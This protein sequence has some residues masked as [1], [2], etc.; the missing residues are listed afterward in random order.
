[1]AGFEVRRLVPAD[2]SEVWRVVTS[3]GD[4]SRWLPL[5]TVET[6]DGPPEVGWSFTGITGVG[7]ARFRDPMTLTE[8]CPPVGG[9]PGFFA[10][11]KTGRVLAGSARVEVRPVPAGT[12]LVW[13]EQII[14]QPVALGRLLA[15]VTDRVG[16]VA[17]GRAVTAMVRT[18]P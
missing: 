9:R 14:L 17:F 15:P 6:D 18:G 2:P 7:G 10:V 11:R 16:A 3:F 12:V 5:T 4:Y 1:M 13:W 8:W